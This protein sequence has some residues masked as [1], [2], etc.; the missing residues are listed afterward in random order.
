M[1][2]KHVGNKS[3][4]N[5][6]DKIKSRVIKEEAGKV[7]KGLSKKRV[8]CR[9]TLGSVGSEEQNFISFTLY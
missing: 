4:W 2:R 9:M 5:F 3:I 8:M 7:E 6:W 1:A